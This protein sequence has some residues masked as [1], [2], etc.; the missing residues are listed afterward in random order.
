MFRVLIITIATFVALGTSFPF[1]N[2]IKWVSAPNSQI[3]LLGL[4]PAGYES[5]IHLF[6]CRTSNNAGTIPGK[7]LIQ[8]GTIV[9]SVPYRGVDYNSTSFEVCE[10]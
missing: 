1:E 5:G 2:S 4:I 7:L 10:N 3:L 6:L 8:G 9:C